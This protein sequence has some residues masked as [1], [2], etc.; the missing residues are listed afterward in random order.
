MNFQLKV[1]SKM[2][3]CSVSL[4]CSVS[5]FNALLPQPIISKT[6]TYLILVTRLFLALQTVCLFQFSTG[7]RDISFVLIGQCENECFDFTTPSQNAHG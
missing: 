7:S 3:I 6:R 1:E 5:C 2:E 4:L